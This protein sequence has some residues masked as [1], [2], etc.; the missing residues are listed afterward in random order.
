MLLL[1]AICRLLTWAGFAT[2]RLWRKNL[3][4]DSLKGRQS[5]WVLLELAATRDTHPSLGL[6]GAQGAP[7]ADLPAMDEL[8]KMPRA[9]ARAWQRWGNTA[10]VKGL[11]AQP[12]VSWR[13]HQSSDPQT[14]CQASQLT[15]VKIPVSH[16]HALT[17]G[18]FGV[19]G[20]TQVST[21]YLIQPSRVLRQYFLTPATCYLVDGLTDL[22]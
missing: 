5:P 20:C 6:E 21:C 14:T 1:S 2:L 4:L 8:H 11:C 13:P 18:G 10:G 9:F 15:D 16:F 12:S 7:P 17:Q 22:T 19:H 3:S